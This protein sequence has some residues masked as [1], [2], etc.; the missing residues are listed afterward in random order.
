[1]SYMLLS[2]LAALV[3]C[4]VLIVRMILKANRTE[5]GDHVTQTVLTRIKAEYRD[6]Q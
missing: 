6:I 3:V 1:M 4:S 5:S 2:G